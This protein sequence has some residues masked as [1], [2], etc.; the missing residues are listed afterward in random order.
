MS[1]SAYINARNPASPSASL[2]RNNLGGT[3]AASNLYAAFA[4]GLTSLPKDQGA[5]SESACVR[6]AHSGRKGG[7][8]RLRTLID[9]GVLHTSIL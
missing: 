5:V 7:F 2:W 9:N 3:K 8:L 4:T 1:A 6:P